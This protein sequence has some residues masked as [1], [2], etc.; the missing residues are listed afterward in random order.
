MLELI[1]DNRTGKK[2]EIVMPTYN[3]AERIVYIM[4]YYGDDFDVVLLDDTSSDSTVTLALEMG[5]T[6]F[7][8]LVENCGEEHY[9]YYVNELTKSGCCFELCAD[10]FISKKD[11]RAIYQKLLSGS[12]VILGRRYDW[13]YGKRLPYDS[14]AMPKGL[15]KSIAQYN[16][17]NIHASLEYIGME[18]GKI[19]ELFYD[20]EHLHI[21][22]GKKYYGLAGRYAYN[23]IAQFSKEKHTWWLFIKRFVRPIFSFP[24]KRF[25]RVKS[26]PT[27]FTIWINHWATLFIA[28]YCFIEQKYL[29]NPKEQRN[30]YAKFYQS[31]AEE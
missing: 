12:C 7:K 31:E 6:V 13:V 29:M 25:W 21:C 30:C 10:E 28:L 15:F 5:A 20:V 11:L 17:S 9:V 23:E 18:E 27:A 4:K 19:R 14:G 1:K 8:R 16:P 24:I 2:L 22:D 26:V 3:E